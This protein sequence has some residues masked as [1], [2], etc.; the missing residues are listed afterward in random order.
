MANKIKV[1]LILELRSAHMS[2]NAIASTR[3]MSKNSVSDVFHISDH[4]SITFNDVKDMS[5]QEV[6]HMFYPDKHAIEKLYED[7]NYEYVHKELKKVGVTLKILWF[8][9]DDKC[10]GNNDIAM[11]Y[12]KFCEGYGNHTIANKLTNHLNHKPGIITEVDWSG[13]T[14]SYVDV[15]IGDKITVY[16]FVATL[17]YSQYAYV[18]PC[19]DMK[20]DTW[21]RCHV[22]MFEFFEGV[23]IRTVCDNLKTG[24]IKHP[25]EGDIVLNESYEALGSHYM[26][27]IMP[28][29]V[30]KPK[31]KASVEGTVGKIAT[32][33][34]AKLRNEVHNSFIELKIA[35][36]KALSD[37]N[38]NP[39]QKR[40]GSRKEIF[41]EEKK[42]LQTLPT[43]PYEIAKWL[44][45]RKVNFDCHVVYE[46]NRYSCPYQHVGK[47]VD[48]KIMDS[49]IEIY[50]LGERIST[51]TK[52]PDYISNRYATQ[53]EDMPAQ[54]LTPEWDDVRIKNWASSVGNS[55]STVIERI[56]SGVKIKE[57]GYN[58]SLSV[59]RLSKT[60]SEARLET[61][62]ELAL[63]KIKAPRYKHLKS[64][65]SS[66]QDQMY[67]E[68]KNASTNPPNPIG[69]YVRGAAYY[70]GNS[71]D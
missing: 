37:F 42:Y 36:S 54:F 56:F 24:V 50:L 19:L 66:N 51:H 15:L 67:L 49:S 52:F 46:K 70:G 55:A 7:P 22:H 63:T 61:A 26:T 65:L 12:T 47:S 57:Q 31:Q 23:T 16:L 48:L 32:A 38:E 58:P 29:G 39:F 44:Y 6:Y 21:L 13:P 18:E 20:Q 10:K 3:Q 5:E 34:I 11:G 41:Q 30:R 53:D 40:E 60:Y 25:R 28:A 33:I 2:R 64:I 45:K 9:Y 8:E 17:P 68:R 71:H 1:K 35:V 27:A 43:I 69:G 4:L 62:C 14:M 59:L